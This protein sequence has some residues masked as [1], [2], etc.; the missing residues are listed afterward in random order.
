VTASADE[1]S[2]AASRLVLAVD[3]GATKT[4]VTL[5]PLAHMASADAI[6]ASKIRT[7]R[8]ATPA[9]PGRLV[10]AVASLARELATDTRTTIVAAGLA[11][12]GPL[13]VASGTIIHS[14]NLGWR[15]V[16]LG[17]MLRD[18]LGVPVALDDD[19]TTAA[20]GESRFGT[21]RGA[22]PFAYLTL[23]SGVGA[24][25]IFGGMVLR[26]AH[27]IAG[28]VG[29]LLIDPKGPRCGCGRRGDVE[30]YVG[31]ASLARRARSAWPS[32]RLA[33]GSA[34]PRDAAGV[35]RAARHGDPTAVR[36]ADEAGRAVARAMA[37][38]AAVVDPEVIA[39]GGALGLAQSRLIRAAVSLARRE[40]M[41]ETARGLVVRRASLGHESCLA[42]A[43]VLASGL[44]A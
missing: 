6:W 10:E 2:G 17:P 8:L 24:G 15:E 41:I 5:R 28:E 7:R 30:A 36:M 21:G 32:G 20:L 26:G 44:A 35:F 3:V 13:D 19:A 9:D 16:P 23:S 33:D 27:G 11:A 38:L 39:V 29:H 40:V 22:D 42:G 1:A 31:G 12:P 25:I 14:P 43:A 37:A 34:A 18:R 4:L